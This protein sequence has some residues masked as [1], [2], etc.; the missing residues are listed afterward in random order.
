MHTQSKNATDKRQLMLTA[1][2]S[3]KVQKSSYMTLNEL[4]LTKITDFK[5]FNV[6][7]VLHG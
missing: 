7:C 6:W 5:E 3:A 2:K 4:K 1:V